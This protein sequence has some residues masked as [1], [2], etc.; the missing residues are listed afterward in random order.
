MRKKQRKKHP[1]E[2]GDAFSVFYYLLVRGFV[3]GK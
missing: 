3:Y 1:K 2:E